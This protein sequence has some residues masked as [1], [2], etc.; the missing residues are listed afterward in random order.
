M[1]PKISRNTRGEIERELDEGRAALVTA[2]K[3]PAGVRSAHG[4]SHPMSDR[5]PPPGSV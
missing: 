5:L 4:A 2:P 3:T 1:I